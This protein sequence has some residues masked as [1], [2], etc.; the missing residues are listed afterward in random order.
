M[1]QKTEQ[2][3][4]YPDWLR[5]V[6]TGLIFA[7]GYYWLST[8]LV[9]SEPSYEIAYSQ[10]KSF[11]QNGAVQEVVIRGLEIEGVLH[12][13]MS[14]GPQQE[15]ASHFNSRLPGFGDESLIPML[16]AQKR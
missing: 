14:I 3:P 4:P 16:E 8:G 2:K 10:F 9:T 6:L 13:P 12:R 15:E 5:Y 1:N 7:L 11:V